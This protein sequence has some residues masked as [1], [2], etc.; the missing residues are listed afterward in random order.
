M[1]HLQVSTVK[2]LE[3]SLAICHGQPPDA[4][5]TFPRKITLLPYFPPLKCQLLPFCHCFATDEENNIRN[6]LKTI[7]GC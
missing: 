5:V 2:V 1:Q 7:F 4:S 3:T 6:H